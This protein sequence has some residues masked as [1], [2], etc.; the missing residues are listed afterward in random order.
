[1]NS[2]N[3]F[4][5][6]AIIKLDDFVKH[7]IKSTPEAKGCIAPFYRVSEDF[8]VSSLDGFNGWRFDTNPPRRFAL[9]AA[10]NDGVEISREKFL[11]E[12][13]KRRRRREP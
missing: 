9:T 11:K 13:K 7:K 2:L 3:Y 6:T 1:M 4:S 10:R 5:T 8:F 12:V